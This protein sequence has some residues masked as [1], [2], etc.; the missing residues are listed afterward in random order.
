M[1]G[2]GGLMPIGGA[3]LGS[4]IPGVGTA[5]GGALGGALGGMGQSMLGGGNPLTGAVS[6][7]LTG[8]LSGMMNGG[9]IAQNLMRGLGMGVASKAPAEN[10][11]SRIGGSITPMTGSGSASGGGG[12]GVGMDLLSK[13]LAQYEEPKP[14]ALPN[15]IAK[16]Y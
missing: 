11:G 16:Y 8:P 14:T 4:V 13:L 10:L 6:G 3:A 7:G 1:G 15:T 12:G 2:L 9:G 5:I